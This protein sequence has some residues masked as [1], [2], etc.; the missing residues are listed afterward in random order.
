M[1]HVV[2]IGAAVAVWLAGTAGA[3]G[4]QAG[5]WVGQQ[6][7]TKPGTVLKIGRMVV[8]DDHRE[9]G[10]RDTHRELVRVYQVKRVSGPWL[11]LV[12]EGAWISGWVPAA[13][14]VTCDRALDQFTRVL[15]ANPRDGRALVSRG[16]IWSETRRYDKAIADFDAAARLDPADAVAFFNRASAWFEK[17][18]YDKSLADLN[19]AIRLDPQYAAAF[20]S[21]GGFWLMRQDYD[22]AI[23]EFNEAARI[24]SRYAAVYF[25]RSMGWMGK[26]E[27]DKAIADLDEAIRLDPRF[28]RA[29]GVRGG[30][31]VSR[32]E[33]EKAIADLNEAIRLEPD[34]ASTYNSRGLAWSTKEEY[35]KA[36]ADF[37]E[38]IR[39]D[40]K[41]AGPYY[42]R[43]HAWYE[44]SA[45]AK[46]IADI[47]E[48]IRLDPQNAAAYQNRAYIWA[49]CPDGRY[50]DGRRAVESA[51]R[52]CE[53][54]H[55]KRPGYLKTLAA[56]CA[57]AGDFDDAVKW[58]EK[59]LELTKDATNLEQGRQRLAL[60]Q[61]KLP[62]HD[63]P[64]VPAPDSENTI[65]PVSAPAQ[66]PS[67]AIEGFPKVD[68][69]V[70]PCSNRVPET[71]AA[72]TET[73]RRIAARIGAEVITLDE[74]KEAVKERVASLPGDYKPDQEE[75]KL[76]R[77]Q[78][79][80]GLIER[81]VLIQAAKR[82][83]KKPAQLT[84]LMDIAD[85][86]WSEEELP[87]LLQKLGVA[88]ASE[89][90]A[91]LAEQGRSL[92]AI[93]ESYKLDFLVRGYMEQKLRARVAPSDSE[94]RAYFDAHSEDFRR[95]E[96]PVPFAEAQE[97]VH[98][99]V[100]RQKIEREMDAFLKTL[101]SQTVITTNVDF[102]APFNPDEGSTKSKR[103]PKTAVE[104]GI[105]C[106]I[107]TVLMAMSARLDAA[108]RTPGRPR[109]GL[110]DGGASGCRWHD[111]D[112]RNRRVGSKHRSS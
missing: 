76:L 47:N 17:H 60:Y 43:G 109:E 7:I 37:D 13:Q 64:A 89:L 34:Y 32:E 39:R 57:E 1:R 5:G 36:I 78:V 65:S 84:M 55:W 54:T 92:D 90:K 93:R 25:V 101:R 51:T 86:V 67:I 49:T 61:A 28:A 79:L 21:R 100:R 85:K 2:T 77:R 69:G 44:K 27:I 40:P 103:K 9:A 8:K 14:V 53:L 107:K 75:I 11:W 71:P 12:S 22:K 19:E 46:A 48:A 23:A 83:L 15:R 111:G 33:P 82:E 45:Y 104:F 26:T 38:A 41:C 58:Q 63:F 91:K 88:N 97:E 105:S 73:G 72:P 52:A 62:F 70:F 24:D 112:R 50:R 68:L 81:S 31:W 30:L 87:P 35:D 18:A 96:G 56:A 4:Q 80:D 16:I 98:R 3:R 102:D 108:R 59:G 94:V 20:L 66:Q 29:Y 6:V 95:P 10:S 110:R 74:L 42:H 99:I 106:F